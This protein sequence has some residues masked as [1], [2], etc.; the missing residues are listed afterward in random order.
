MVLL[1]HDSGMPGMVSCSSPLLDER[2]F[3]NAVSKL[4]RKL[5]EGMILHPVR[6]PEVGRPKLSVDILYL[7][8][9]TWVCSYSSNSMIATMTFLLLAPLN[10]S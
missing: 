10:Q 3:N 7:V 1:V 2:T 9:G 4:S 8:S 5:F 6:F